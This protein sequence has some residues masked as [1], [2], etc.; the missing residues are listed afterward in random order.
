MAGR[1]P[2]ASELDYWLPALASGARSRGELAVTLADS[3]EY[4]ADTATSSPQSSSQGQVTRIYLASLKRLPDPEGYGYWAGVLDEG[5][6]SIFALANAFT[7]APEFT[8]IYA[9]LDDPAFVDAVYRNVFGRGPDAGGF[10]YWTGRVGQIGRAG[11]M[12][13]FSDSPE[14]VASTHTFPLGG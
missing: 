6:V 9:S 8:N 2:V 14:Y 11:V 13:G 3:P 5:G 1:R 4:T 12:V 10:A 7:Q